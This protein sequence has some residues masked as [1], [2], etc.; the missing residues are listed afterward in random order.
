MTALD[1]RA[2]TVHELVVDDDV[3]VG[4][5]DEHAKRELRRAMLTAVC[6]PGYQVP[7][8]SRE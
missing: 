5:L 7:F 8:G 3:D 2:P 4:I 6:V 1:D